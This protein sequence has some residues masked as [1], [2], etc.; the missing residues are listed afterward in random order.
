MRKQISGGIVLSVVAQA[1]TII[2]GLVYTPYMIRILGQNEYGLYQLVL[3]VVNYLNLMNFGFSGAYIRYYSV[4]KTKEDPREVANVNGMFM[5]V[6]LLIAALCVAAGAVLY[7]RID[8]LGD[9]LTA[10][11][12]DI[13][14]K[15]LVMMVASL[16][17]SF[18][19]S[20][21]TAYMSANE[22][23]IYQKALNIVLNIVGPLVTLPLLLWGM[24][25]VGVV[26]VS[27]GIGIVRLGVNSWYCFRKLGMEINLRYTDKKIF[28]GLLGYTFFIFLSDVVD[29]LNT[30]VDKFLL[31][32]I[33]G[34]V[35]VA[36]YSVGF[37]LKNY[38][39]MVSWIVSEM[40]IPEANRLALEENSDRKLTELFTKVGRYNNYICLLVLTGFILVGRQFVQLWVGD[41]YEN[42]YYVGM[43]LMFAGYIPSVQTLG[44]NIQNAKNMHKTRSV[45][46][47]GIAVVNVIA[48]IFLIR[49]WGEVG[50]ALGTLFAVLIGSGIF[51]NWYYRAK[52]RLDIGYFWKEILKWT[53]PAAALCAGSYF[54]LRQFAIVSWGRLIAA[55][56]VYG[57]VYCALL[58]LIGMNREEKDGILRLL[59]KVK[60][61]RGKKA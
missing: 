38:Y 44:V 53:V 24:G 17:V 18:P 42:A 6:F 23:F 46:Y 33:I 7:F 14:R 51:M 11:D 47:F 43:I 54:L 45:V 2:V 41:G 52:I 34:T 12:Y 26:A 32:R 50:T 1:I 57:A 37:N 31:G 40:F 30:N 15:L 16:A 9:K 5:K 28:A 10:A 36:V 20:L 59:R 25:S 60:G 48:S 27:L 22:R 35:S 39:Q 13:A 61:I 55:A 19:N 29:Q 49:K 21:F 4:A 3:S 56:A 58:W 8:V